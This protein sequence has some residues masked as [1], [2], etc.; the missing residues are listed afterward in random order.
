[1]NGLLAN[2]ANRKVFEANREKIEAQNAELVQVAAKAIARHGGRPAT[3]QEALTGGEDYELLVA[4]AADALI[5]DAKAGYPRL[6]ASRAGADEVD[7]V[8]ATPGDAGEPV[9]GEGV[10]PDENEWFRAEGDPQR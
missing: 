1:V 6:E 7:A 5:A 8:A 2:D 3:P 10:G 9:P 4:C